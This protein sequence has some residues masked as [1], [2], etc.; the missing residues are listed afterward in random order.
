MYRDTGKVYL[1]ILVN[2]YPRYSLFTKGISPTSQDQ[3]EN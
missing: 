1:L 3:L 2:F